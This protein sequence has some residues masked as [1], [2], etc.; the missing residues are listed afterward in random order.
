M[1][2]KA[3]QIIDGI[4]NGL[5]SLKEVLGETNT[6]PASS[7]ATH[8]NN[9]LAIQSLPSPELEA[10][11]KAL[12]SDK[13]PEAVNANLIC[14]ISSDFDK[15]ERARGI[16]ELMIQ[17][18]IKKKKF[19]DYGCGEGHVSK[20]ALE[21]SPA[22]SAGYD[23]K[24]QWTNAAG[25]LMTDS[26]DLLQQNKP[27]D[28]IMIYDVIDHIE[29]E[30]P[31]DLL[32]R[33]KSLLADDGRIYIRCH[34]VTSKHAT[35][36]YLTLNKAYIHLVFTPQEL[37]DITTDVVPNFGVVDPETYVK[38]FE[39]VGLKVVNRRNTNDKIEPFFKI[40]KIAN[41]INC[42]LGTVEFPDSLGVQFVDW[43]LSK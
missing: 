5:Q 22:L 40:T 43:C 27:Y 10:L 17:Q 33:V 39:S 28:V 18:D 37:A 19:L 9:Q 42:A 6:P 7:L 29:K 4:I 8:I 16:F 25:C 26:I 2:D 32:A 14:D 24:K 36:S 23:I 13:W 3:N 31:I 21:Y 12:W 35:H 30:H 20:I 11:K 38:W 1:N 34:P 15:I 41:K